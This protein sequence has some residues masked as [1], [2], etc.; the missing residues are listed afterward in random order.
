MKR[1]T[2]L[3]LITLLLSAMALAQTP[4]TPPQNPPAQTAAPRPAAP[5]PSAAASSAVPTGAAKIAV[6]DF[7]RAFTGTA[8]GKKAN[9]QFN[10]E[11]QKRQS[12]F[13]AKQKKAGDLQTRLTTGEKVLDAA[14]KA[15]ITRQIEQLQT[16]LTRDNED[17]Q[18]DLG[19]LQQRLFTPIMSRVQ[20]VVKD[21]AT[22]NGFAVVFDVGGQSNNILHYD[23]VAD[24]TTEI[25]RKVDATAPKAPAA[26][27]TPPKTPTPPEQKKP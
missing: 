26:P 24:I 23:D 18:R 15:D 17:A 1:A 10:G 14:A 8:E 7:A 9:D 3:I 21:Y 19:E 25:I 13:E 12:Q 11:L 4:T 22:E 20:Q 27:A 16:E 2:F 5:A 6:I